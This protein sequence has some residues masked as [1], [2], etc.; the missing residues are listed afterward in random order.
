MKTGGFLMGYLTLAI[1]ALILV[2]LILAM[3]VSF[4]LIVLSDFIPR[5]LYQ[6]IFVA[7]AMLMPIF[8][9]TSTTSLCFIIGVKNRNSKLLLPYLIVDTLEVIIISLIWITITTYYEQ[10]YFGIPTIITSE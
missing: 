8:F 3:N 1:R 7:S 10:L 4:A 9:I 5:G 2:C 6:I